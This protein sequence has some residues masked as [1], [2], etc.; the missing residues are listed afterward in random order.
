MIR[1]H[2]NRQILYIASFCN[3]R[4]IPPKGINSPSDVSFT[5]SSYRIPPWVDFFL[6]RILFSPD[7]VPTLW[8]ASIEPIP[9][10]WMKTN[11][12]IIFFWS[13]KIN[14]LMGAIDISTPENAVSKFS[15]WVSILGK[16]SIK[17]Q[18]SLPGIFWLASIWKIDSE[19]VYCL[20]ILSLRGTKQSIS[21]RIDTLDRFILCDEGT[22]PF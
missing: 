8:F 15:K 6:F 22:F 14:S 7:I 4:I 10:E 1:P 19:D 16:F 18:F 12:S 17:Y 2:L 3:N 13:C 21:Q 11:L 9:F 5:R 20:M